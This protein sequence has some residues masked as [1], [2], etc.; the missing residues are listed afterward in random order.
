MGT[1]LHRNVGSWRTG[2]LW[3]AAVLPGYHVEM[4]TT[5]PV[6]LTR[7]TL[8][9]QVNRAEM[10]LIESKAKAAGMSVGNY[11]RSV[12]GLPE[13][14]A[15]RPTRAQMESEQDAAWHILQSMGVDPA[16][17]FPADES[18]LDEYR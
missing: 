5:L 7:Q 18:W 15:G 17:F 4:P 2:K 11:I 8:R 13:R 3:N 9:A 6:A 1:G 10:M 14:A 12:L 16:P